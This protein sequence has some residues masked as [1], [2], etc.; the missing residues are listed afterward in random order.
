MRLR[1]LSVCALF[2]SLLLMIA[3]GGNKQESTDETA[4]SPKPAAKPAGGSAY[5]ASKATAT[6]TGK[7]VYEGNPPVLAKLQMNADPYCMTA[8]K[9][10]VLEETVQVNA[11][12]TLKDVLVY[13]KDGADKWTYTTP[14]DPVVLDQ[15]GCMYSPHI[16]VLM[17][18]QPLKILNSDPTLHNIHPQPTKNPEFNQ[19]MPTKGMEITKTF[20]NDEIFSVKCDV[21][22]WMNAHVAVMKNPFY[23]VS[24]ADGSFTIKV[25]AGTYTLEAW[26][27][28]LGTQSASVTV[29]DGESK[30]VPF[31]FKGM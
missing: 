19:G 15:M 9:D 26:Q 12:K 3:C 5:D 14:T 21:H 25:P 1:K 8:H 20:A 2:F 29:A 30:D 4:A 6:I 16:I 23:A 18:N 10:A 7:I 22:R 24:G 28:K 27:E 17:Q 13:I 11:D 31:T